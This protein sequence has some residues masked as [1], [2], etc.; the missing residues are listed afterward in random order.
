MPTTLED[1]RRLAMAMPGAEESTMWGSA[2]WKVRKVLFVWERPL[3]KKD[4]EHLGAA[5]PSGAVI[6]ARVEHEQAKLAL[7]ADPSGA[8]FTTPHFDGHP[9]ILV[10]L[11][12]V[13]LDT[14]EEVVVEAWLDRATPTAVKQYLAARE[15]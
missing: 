9:I 12:R 4:L 5:A 6:G 14:L 3:R 13:D 2:A 10:A 7:L 15:G 1:V 8:F 11:D